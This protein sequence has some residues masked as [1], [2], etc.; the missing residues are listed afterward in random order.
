MC[1]ICFYTLRIY[2]SFQRYDIELKG[3]L[4]NPTE[5]YE[6]HHV[7]PIKGCQLNQ[8]NENTISF[9][10]YKRFYEK[11]HIHIQKHV[12]ARRL[13]FEHYRLTW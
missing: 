11:I 8:Y 13:P 7:Y 10:R 5:F 9:M 3:V 1:I 2:V 4:K 6:N 12:K